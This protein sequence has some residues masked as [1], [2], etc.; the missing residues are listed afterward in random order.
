MVVNQEELSW[1]DGIEGSGYI[2]IPPHLVKQICP[3]SLPPKKKPNVSYGQLNNLDTIKHH[4]D[5][6]EPSTEQKQNDASVNEKSEREKPVSNLSSN[7][8][9]MN[10]MEAYSSEVNK[11]N[12]SIYDNLEKKLRLFNERCEQY[13]TEKH[14]EEKHFHSCFRYS[15]AIFLVKH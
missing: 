6:V 7:F 10:L 3:D 8:A 14:F 11:Y 9:T 1:P 15:S 12:S 2:D 5:D 4:N 13:G